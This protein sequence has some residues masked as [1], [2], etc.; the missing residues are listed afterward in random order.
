VG[1]D[2]LQAAK[3]IKSISKASVL[4]KDVGE[5][6]TAS[7]KLLE[8]ELEAVGHASERGKQILK[9]MEEIDAALTKVKTTEFVENQKFLEL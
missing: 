1:L 5:G 8:T 2:V 7:R 6:L 9:E 3:L 4:A